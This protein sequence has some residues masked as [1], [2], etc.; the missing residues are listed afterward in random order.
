MIGVVVV[1]AALDLGDV[2]I[3]QVQF[4]VIQKKPFLGLPKCL[5]K[6]LFN[7]PRGMREE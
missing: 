3:N 6:R 4:E 1:Y 2:S 7:L 5:E